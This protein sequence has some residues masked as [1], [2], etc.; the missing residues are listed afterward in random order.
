MRTIGVGFG[1]IAL[2]AAEGTVQAL[3]DLAVVHGH[4]FHVAV[5]W[6]GPAAATL[7]IYLDGE[8]VYDGGSAVETSD[9][10]EH[11]IIGRATMGYSFFHG[12]IDEVRIRAAVVAAEDIRTWMHR[13]IA[14][15]HPDFARLLAA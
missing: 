10:T 4:W 9:T 3:A 1:I 11:F 6:A 14:S 8:V 5:V 13:R 2:L 7:L 15:N 12:A